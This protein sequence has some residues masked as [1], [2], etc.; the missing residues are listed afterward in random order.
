MSFKI[1]PDDSIQLSGP[2]YVGADIPLDARYLVATSGDLAGIPIKYPGMQVFAEDDKKLFFLEDITTDKWSEIGGTGN[3]AGLGSSLTAL[4][5]AG[6]DITGGTGISTIYNTSF[7][8]AIQSVAVGGLTSQPVSYWKT[9]TIVEVLDEL[10]FPTILPSVSP[11]KSLS[12]SVNGALGDL[13]VGTSVSR[14]LTA[15]FDQGSIQDGNG[16]I[17]PEP[18][19]GAAINYTFDG[20]SIPS[21][22]TQAGNSYDAGSLTVIPG[23][24]VWNVSANYDAG[25]GVYYDNKLV[26]RNNLDAQRVAGAVGPVNSSSSEGHYPWYV[27]KSSS[28]ITAAAM[29][30]AIEN[31]LATKYVAD[32]NG[33]LS[34]NYNLSAQYLGVAHPA[35][36]TTKTKYYV[37]ALDTGGITVVFNA[38]TTVDVTT[39]NWSNVSYR[40]YGSKS[41][42]TETRPTIILRN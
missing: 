14:T 15:N 36:S 26:E 29:K 39:T 11:D 33:D 18:L 23:A 35:S 5:N 19:V 16:S 28:P 38:S 1:S 9:K 13:E 42:K 17:N 34:V 20:T 24:N 41:A 7:D 4:P 6:I 37:S 40:V 3:L 27:W 10:M 21:S 12:L 30:T 31:G 25:A 2:I 8:D 22:V 32:S